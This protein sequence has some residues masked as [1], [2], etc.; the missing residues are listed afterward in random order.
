MPVLAVGVAAALTASTASI[1]P[2]DCA[3]EL[4]APRTEARAGRAVTARDLIGLR[5]F[6]AMDN[7]AGQQVFSL[8]PDGKSAALIL[9]RADPDRDDYCFGLVLIS[10]DGRFA[11]RLLDI[12][13]E[14]IQSAVDIRGVPAVSTGVLRAL[15][16]VWSP[17][18]RWIA[19]LRRDRGVTRVWRV[20]LDGGP[21]RSVGDLGTDALAVRWSGSGDRMIVAIRPSLDAGLAAVDREGRTG[22]HFDERFQALSDDRPRPALPL[23]Q[24]EVAVDPATGRRDTTAGLGAP[25]GDGLQAVSPSGNRAAVQQD[26]PG[27][28]YSAAPL[29]VW[30]GGAS[31]ACAP[32]ICGDHVAGLWWLAT[33]TLLFL[34][35]G[36]PANGGRTALFRWRIG[37]DAEP[38]RVLETTDALFGCGLGGGKLVCAREGAVQPRQIV[39]IDPA[40]G[41][42]AVVF[43]PNPGFASLRLGSVER[44]RWRLPDGV[45]TYGDLVLPPGHRPGDLHPL[46]VTQYI[47]RGFLRGG[48]GDEYPL[49]LLAAHGFAVLSYQRPRLLAGADK[50]RD[51]IGL[52]KIN[53]DGWAERRMIVAA[54]EA[55]VDR[56]IA[57]GVV[58]PQ[59]IGLTGMSDGATTTQFALNHSDR[60]KAAAISSCC[61]EPSGL[62][63]AGPAY[64]EATLDWGY[65]QP[66]PGH[67]AFWAPMSLAAHARGWRTPI[68]VQVPDAEY[69][70]GL[71][72]LEAFRLAGAPVDAYVFPDEHHLKW[73]PAHRLAV[74]ERSVA[75]FDFWLRDVRAADANRAPE[76]ARWEG[77]RARLTGLNG[78]PATP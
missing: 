61:D 74:Y 78:G 44:L 22:F 25:H 63:V 31:L 38:R 10:L 12:G 46:I 20:G 62:F 56:T 21:A 13:G 42:L 24:V 72:T 43:D 36:Y 9:R 71:E 73:H 19:Y 41:R 49:Q 17:D 57:L 66:G 37:H 75:W 58:D 69:R 4:L 32:A 7:A 47:S 35:A 59:R 60:F 30:A 27:H 14:Y 8:S 23:P 33:D 64:G 18:G 55:G 48:T 34:R 28:P 39:T 53:I 67:A 76:I 45:E 51:L 65:P 54:L 50:V 2:R 68:L 3:A 77:M 11:P 26:D 15:P 40:S 70:M 52:Q 6:G 29:R 16:P 5:D 1:A